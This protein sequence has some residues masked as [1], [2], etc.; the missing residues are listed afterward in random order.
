MGVTSFGCQLLLSL[1]QSR[2]PELPIVAHEGRCECLCCSRVRYDRVSYERMRYARVS[3]VRMSYDRVMQPHRRS[4]FR[5]CP[6]TRPARWTTRMCI[7]Y[8]CEGTCIRPCYSLQPL[9]QPSIAH[10]SLDR[11]YPSLD[12][13]YPSLAQCSLCVPCAS[14]LLIHAHPVLPVCFARRLQHKT[15]TQMIKNGTEATMVVHRMRSTGCSLNVSLYQWERVDGIERMDE[16]SIHP[17]IDF[18]STPAIR[19]GT[20]MSAMQ[21]PR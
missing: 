6:Q 15:S 3:C 13:P 4:R 11:S 14:R 2:P 5:P 1:S 18:E 10:P 8:L 7:W 19:F 16:F 17:G 12:R 9:V 21:Y 20:L